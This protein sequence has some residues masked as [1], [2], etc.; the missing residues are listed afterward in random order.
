MLF[1]FLI[2]FNLS[3]CYSFYFYVIIIYIFM[4]NI[5]YSI[6][7]YKYEENDSEGF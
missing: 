3:F 5:D 1:Y 4:E 7:E 6:N 2:R